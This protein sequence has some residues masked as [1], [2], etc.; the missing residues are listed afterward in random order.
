MKK[1]SIADFSSSHN[2]WEITNPDMKIFNIFVL[3]GV[4]QATPTA[5][6]VCRLMLTVLEFNNKKT[7]L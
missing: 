5:D 7:P 1:I 3:L 2:R 4:P 6:N